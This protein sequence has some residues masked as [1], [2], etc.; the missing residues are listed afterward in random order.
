MKAVALQ[1]KYALALV[2]GGILAAGPA[3]ADKPRRIKMATIIC[4]F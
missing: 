4:V 1:M 3:M 2:I